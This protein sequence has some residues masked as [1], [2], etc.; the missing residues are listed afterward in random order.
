MGEDESDSNNNAT[1]GPGTAMSQSGNNEREN[2]DQTKII[3][4]NN[5][6]TTE[7]GENTLLIQA[8]QKQTL[9]ERHRKLVLLSVYI[10]ND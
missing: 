1:P 6:V 5:V 10:R 4:L 9:R 3:H 8:Q 7:G 2:T